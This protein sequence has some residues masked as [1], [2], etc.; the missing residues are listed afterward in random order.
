MELVDVINNENLKIVIMAA[1]K[2]IVFAKDAVF[3]LVANDVLN[4][5]INE[6]TSKEVYQEI[7]KVVEAGTIIGHV[8]DC[9]VKTSHINGDGN[10]FN[11]QVIVIGEREEKDAFGETSYFQSSMWINSP[12]ELAIGENLA[13]KANAF[14]INRN[15][16]TRGLHDRARFISSLEAKKNVLSND[17]QRVNERYSLWFTEDM[18]TGEK[19]KL[20][21]TIQ[22]SKFY[23]VK[24]APREVEEV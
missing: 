21:S 1:E 12:K 23:T 19:K 9:K 4:V 22:G 11:V 2:K 16:D 17:G 8:R 24:R 18:Q 5:D 13:I 6:Q 20:I 10:S 7:M 14:V 15:L 3:A